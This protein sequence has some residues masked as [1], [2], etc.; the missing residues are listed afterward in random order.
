M[1]A[2]QYATAMVAVVTGGTDPEQA[3]AGLDRTLKR[4]GHTKL[5]TAILLR[6]LTLLTEEEKRNTPTVR[7]ARKEDVATYESAIQKLATELGLSGTPAVVI[8]DSL[9][10]GY[11]LE[12]KDTLVD[13]SYKRTLLSLYRNITSAAH[14]S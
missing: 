3:L 10:G 12:T 14:T 2:H 4:R 13:K 7:I 6:V 11:V 9:I 5:R 8:D 1:D